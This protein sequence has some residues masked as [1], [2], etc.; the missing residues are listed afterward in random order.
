MEK[1]DGRRGPRMTPS[2]V[3]VLPVLMERSAEGLW[4][5]VRELNELLPGLTRTQINNAVRSAVAQEIA[6]RTPVEPYAYRMKPD[7]SDEAH[8][9]VERAMMVGWEAEPASSEPIQINV[10]AM[11][12]VVS[13]ARHEPEATVVR[14]AH[15]E[16]H[17]AIEP[18][19]FGSEGEV[20]GGGGVVIA[21]EIISWL[22]EPGN[23]D[24]RWGLRP[25][26]QGAE[27]LF[28]TEAGAAQFMMCWMG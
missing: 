3:A 6:E 19:I 8:D 1:A 14:L 16:Q 15:T 10:A 28:E 27:L 9:F 22:N 25:G 20:L 2:I 26:L 12:S 7:L 4:T 21:P 13:A 23:I 18:V 24:G 17:F 5:T 11:G